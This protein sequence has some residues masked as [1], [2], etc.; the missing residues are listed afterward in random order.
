MRQIAGK[1]HNVND[2]TEF[3]RLNAESADTDPAA[4]TVNQS[5]E[6]CGLSQNNEQG[7]KCRKYEAL[8]AAVIKN[9]KKYHN[10]QARAGEYNL[11]DVFV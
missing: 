7:Q 4:C 6:Q 2:F 1:K 8:K 10:R 11:F 3:G 9:G 5:A